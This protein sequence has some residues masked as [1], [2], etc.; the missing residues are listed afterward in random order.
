[1]GVRV[2]GS[3]CVRNWVIFLF[4][5]VFLLLFLFMN[6]S[7]SLRL[8]PRISNLHNASFFTCA[9]VRGRVQ[10]GGHGGREVES[11]TSWRSGGH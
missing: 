2:G 11:E 5:L 4:I 1:V 9:F 8:V 10:T 3:A 7:S 6:M